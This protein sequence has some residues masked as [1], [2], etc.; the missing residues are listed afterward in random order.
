MQWIVFF[1]VAEHEIDGETCDSYLFF[2]SQRQNY[3]LVTVS[4]LSFNKWKQQ[5]QKKSMVEYSQK[6]YS[7]VPLT[8]GCLHFDIVIR[9]GIAITSSI[10]NE[11]LYV[12]LLVFVLFDLFA[13]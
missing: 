13:L 1:S 3:N 2:A 5:Q 11:L 12:Y 9:L 8:F 10:N 4:A 6:N 7:F